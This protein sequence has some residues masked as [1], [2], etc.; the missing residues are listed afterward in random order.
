MKK[1]LQHMFK[2]LLIIG[3]GLILIECLLFD[4]RLI[5]GLLLVTFASLCI[6][7]V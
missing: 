6:S 1:K 2:L 3:I 7:E 5:F 4:E